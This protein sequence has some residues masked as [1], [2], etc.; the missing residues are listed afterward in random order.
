MGRWSLC[1]RETQG[2]AEGIAL[3]AVIRGC[4][5]EVLLLPWG[6]GACVWQRHKATSQ[7]ATLR[8]LILRGCGGEVFLLPWGAGA[9]VWQRRKATSQGAALRALIL[10]GC[11]GVFLPWG[12]GASAWQFPRGE[13]QP[14]VVA[15][16]Q[17]VVVAALLCILS[18]DQGAPRL[19]RRRRPPGS[20]LHPAGPWAGQCC[21]TR[22]STN[23][24]DSLGE[25]G[26]ANGGR[27]KASGLKTG[28]AKPCRV[29]RGR[30][31][32]CAYVLAEE[33]TLCSTHL[34]SEQHTA[35]EALDPS[36]EPGAR[37]GQ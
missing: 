33:A 34:T 27:R 29:V 7:G 28:R 6:V 14:V 8:A 22:F 31:V 17:P 1:V 3:G 37:N 11:G 19:A 25:G 5:G 4:G 35:A 9:C 12:A 23:R 10:R 26:V 30:I 36:R 24:V 15:A 21:A 18:L 20:I 16:T 13:I 32:R 2:D